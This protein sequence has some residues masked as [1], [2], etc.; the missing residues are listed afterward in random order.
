MDEN[1]PTLPV[2]LNLQSQTGMLQGSLP[3][4]PQESLTLNRLEIN[5]FQQIF[6]PSETTLK[7]S[8]YKDGDGDH[9]LVE[10]S[11]TLM[12]SEPGLRL[13]P[14]FN[15]SPIELF[16]EQSYQVRY[17]ITQGSPLRMYGESFTLETSW[18]DALPLNINK[19]DVQ[20]GIFTPLNLELYEPDTPEKREAMLKVLEESNYIVIP[21][22]RAYD[23][24]PRIA[25]TLPAD[26]KILSGF[27]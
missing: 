27:I 13:S 6:M 15:F 5:N 8:I 22:N 24:M 9:P 10:A 20:G 1:R 25:I 12:F 19:Y 18:D 7:V 17:E 23:A 16:G 26:F 4:T 21:S 3:V 11:Q 2:D 14:T